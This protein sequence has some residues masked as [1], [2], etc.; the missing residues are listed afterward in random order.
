MP[1]SRCDK[2]NVPTR[3]R[4]HCLTIKGSEAAD[5]AFAPSQGAADIS[6]PAR[7]SFITASYGIDTA[8]ILYLNP[9]SL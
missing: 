2:I 4:S 9:N 5:K 6:P 7:D 3:P 1:G 8:G